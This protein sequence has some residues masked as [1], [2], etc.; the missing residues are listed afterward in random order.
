M[1]KGFTLVELSIVLVIIG[2]LIGGVLKGKGMI[3]NS[4][5]KRIKSDVDAIVAATY[6]YQDSF[7]A[8]PGDDAIARN[9]SGIAIAAGNGNGLFDGVVGAGESVEA[10]QAFIAMGLMSGNAAGVTEAA[11]AKRNPFGN[12]YQLRN[13]VIAAGVNANAIQTIMPNHLIQELDVKYDDG[14]QA[15]GDIRSNT[16]YGTAGNA[17]LTWYAF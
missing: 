2:L 13:A 1:R 15:T 5:M 6:S 14:N 10:W 7:N 9:I 17:T 8:L 3:D 4:K 11:I 16:A 12:T